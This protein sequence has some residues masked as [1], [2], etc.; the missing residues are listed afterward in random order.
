VKQDF[1][2]G[3][4][5]W[6][7]QH[8][9]TVYNTKAVNSLPPDS[10]HGSTNEWTVKYWNNTNLSGLPAW[11]MTEPP[12]EIRFNAGLGAPVGTRGVKEDNFST[13]WETT[14]HFEGGFYN[15]IS[16]A[17]DGVFSWRESD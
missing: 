17:D 13:R 5:L 11:T 15:F 14:S 8:G 4:I 7:P 12:G 16:Q 3:Y 1:E 2:G 10:G 6:H 9:T